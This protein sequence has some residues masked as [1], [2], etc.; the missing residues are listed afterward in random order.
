M[1]FTYFFRDLQ[2]L[3]Q[4][5][6][7][8]L[9][10]L[11]N[12]R[13]ISVWDAGCAHGPEPYTIAILLRENMGHFM[14][15]NTRIYATDIDISNQFGKVIEEGVY[16]DEEIKRIPDEIRLKYFRESGRPGH[17]QIADEL[18]S[19][20]R[21]HRSDL[22]D[23]QPICTDIGLI[24]CKNVLLHFQDAQRVDVIRMYHNALQ[25]NGFLMM[26]QTQKMPSEL[27]DLFDQV[28]PNAQLF[29]KRCAA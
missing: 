12:R 8:A 9:P 10:S 29:K 23:L 21:F 20:V 24:V 2:T 11:K 5:V 26:E 4:M 15:R 27:E 6:E 18:R 7:Y 19:C 28:V 1:A 16:P 22:L 3:E 14:F 13:Q 17:F 25:D